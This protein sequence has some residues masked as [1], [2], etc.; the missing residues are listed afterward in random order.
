[1]MVPQSMCN[2]IKCNN[3]FY[4]GAAKNCMLMQKSI[5]MGCNRLYCMMVQQS[6]EWWCTRWWNISI[7]WWWIGA[8][9]CFCNSALYDGETEHCLILQQHPSSCVT[10]AGITVQRSNSTL[11]EI[12]FLCEIVMAGFVAFFFGFLNV[13]KWPIW[14]LNSPK[15]YL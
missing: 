1:M 2:V 3:A 13:C 12:V 9:C 7:I 5:V 6:I 15:Y 11:F 4:K 14:S 8:N 10:L